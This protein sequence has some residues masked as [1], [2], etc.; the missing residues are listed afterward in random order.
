MEYS[1]TELASEVRR[2]PFGVPYTTVTRDRAL[3]GNTNI[4]QAIAVGKEYKIGA[5][6]QNL[7]QV[8]TMVGPIIGIATM[9]PT[10]LQESKPVCLFIRRAD[11]VRNLFE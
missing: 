2:R 7:T 11:V 10:L 6:T 9:L 1:I 4:R 3:I 8:L 5:F